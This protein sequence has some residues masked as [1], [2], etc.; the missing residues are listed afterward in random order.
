MLVQI[1]KTRPAYYLLEIYRG[2]YKVARTI[3]KNNY[4]SRTLNILPV[5]HKNP[6][7]RANVQYSFVYRH[8]DNGAF[9]DFPKISDH[10]PNI[11]ED[12][13]KLFQ[14]RITKHRQE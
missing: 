2:Y 3:G 10:Y 8:T 13:P 12:F 6:Y 1:K 5:E 4:V 11:F 14:R 7:L 9:D